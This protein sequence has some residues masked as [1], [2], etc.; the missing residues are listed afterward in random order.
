MA[1]V[2]GLLKIEGTVE[3][4]TFY[5]K[6]GENYVRRKGGVSRERILT[7]PNFIRTRENGA[8]FSHSAAAGKLLRTA[9]GSIVFKAKD[10]KLSSRMLQL[11][12]RIKNL[13]IT[14]LRGQRKVGIGL[15]TAQGKQTLK[16][17]D[18]NFNAP[19]QSVLFT[20]FALDTTTGA[21]SFTDFVPAEQLQFP[22]GATHFSMQSMVLHL[23]FETED[24]GIAYSPVVNLPIN[25]TANSSVLTPS[26]VPTG[27]GVQL[28]LLQVSFYQEL[29]GVQYSLK[30]EMY[31]MLSILEVL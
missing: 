21:V 24:S 27:S 18:F 20:P 26:S 25:Y 9:L 31:N 17:F 23:D 14:S 4:L 10:S 11:M 6:D 2:K 7:D 19:L 12:S 30:N 16:G 22:Q 13:D 1:K 28:F 3:D 8:E 5:K 15:A 29:N